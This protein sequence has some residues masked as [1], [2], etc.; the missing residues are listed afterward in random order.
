VPGPRLRRSCARP[1][2]ATTERSGMTI[3]VAHAKRC[4]M[5]T[6]AVVSVA[7]A[8]AGCASSSPT[9]RQPGPPILD[10]DSGSLSVDHGPPPDNVAKEVAVRMFLDA[11]SRPPAS[12]VPT[13]KLL[14]GFVTMRAG[15]GTPPLHRQ[16]AWVFVYNVDIAAS[17]PVDP[18]SA[19]PKSEAERVFIITGP[20]RSNETDYESIG[21]GICSAR[22]TPSATNGSSLHFSGQG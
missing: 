7:L 19:R 18:G 2:P 1:D 13:Y 9:D 17:C 21:T 3:P 12:A 16:P 11:A 8:C 20:D 14:N 6:A 22:K 4:S 15:F 5:L 10:E